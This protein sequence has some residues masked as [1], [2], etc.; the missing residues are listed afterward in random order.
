MKT[1]IN[2]TLEATL[3]SFGLN[4]KEIL[5]YTTLLTLGQAPASQIIEESGLKKGNTYDVLYKLEELGLLSKFQK[6]AKMIFQVE[7]PDKL[8][9][10]AENQKEEVDAAEKSLKAL[11]PKLNSQYKSSVGKPT[12]RYYEGLEGIKEV[13]E[14]I[15]AT[16]DS[17]VYG[18]A[19]IERID[20]EYP[21][22]NIP[23][24]RKENNIRSEAIFVKDQTTEEIKADDK[25]ENRKSV[26]IDGKTYPLPA[27]IDVYGDKVAMLTFENGEFKGLIVQNEAIATSLRSILKLGMSK[28]K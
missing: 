13:Y 6:D 10:L 14:D 3:T 19:D 23:N 17:T 20:T 28:E 15:F 2:K 4:E 24:R 11:L 22:H 16:K 25:K 8:L 21:T 9:K 27:E 26:L 7:P 5:I 18:C 1:E 12:V